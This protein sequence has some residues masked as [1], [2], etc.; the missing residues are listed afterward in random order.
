LIILHLIARLLFLLLAG[1]GLPGIAAARTGIGSHSIIYSHDNGGSRLGRIVPGAH[2]FQLPTSTFSLDSRHFAIAETDNPRT[3]TSYDEAGRVRS[4]VDAAR[5]TT[6][7][8]YDDGAGAGRRKEVIQHRAAPNANLVTSYR[9]DNAGRVRYVTDPRGNTVETQYDAQ[10]RQT[11]VIY[12]ATDELPAS[13]TETR[14]DVAGRR[15][16]AIDQEGKI[17]R[18]R[19]DG[20]GRLVEVRQYLDQTLAASDF[21]FNLPASTANVVSTTFAYDELGHQ[22]TQQDSLGRVTSYETDASGRRLKR[23]LPKTAAEATAPS[24]ILDYDT[25]GN[26]WHRTDLAGKTTTFEYD[27][28]GR[29]KRKLADSTHPSLAYSHAIARVEY[30]YDVSGARTAARTYGSTGTLLYSEATPRTVSGAVDHKETASGTLGYQYYINGQLKDVVSSNTDGVNVG[31]RYDELNRLQYVDDASGSSLQAPNP[32]VSVYTYNASGSLE[33]V[34]YA[35]GI[36]HAYNYDTLNRLRTLS[37]SNLQ[38]QILHSYT[39]RLR[40]SGH[41]RQVLEG[42]KTTTYDYDELYRLTGETVTGGLAGTNGAVSYTLDKV[43]NRSSRLSFVPSVS[44]VVNQ[45]H[46]A[47][48]RLTDIDG[49]SV[50]YDLNGNTTSGSLHDLL[51]SATGTFTDV[52]DFENRLI[53]RRKSDG[54]QINIS[55]DPDGNRVQKTIL[56]G[57][58]QLVSATY[59]LVDTNNLTGYSQVFEERSTTYGGPT[60]VSAVNTYTYGSDLISCTNFN[61]AAST[62]TTRFYAYDGHGSVRELTNEAGLVTETY[63]Y[64]AFGVLVASTSTSTSTL[65]SNLNSY[66]YSGEQWDFD[67]SLYFNRARY[68]NPNSG[69][70]WSMD[71][72]EGS[73]SDPASLHKYLYANANPVSGSDP[74]GHM[75]LSEIGVSSFI[76][77]FIDNAMAVYRIWGVYN[78]IQ[79]ILGAIDYVRGIVNLL[80]DPSAILEHLK[81]YDNLVKTSAEFGSIISRE[82][83]E[84]GFYTLMGNAP[85]IT[86]EL[87]R[88]PDLLRQAG[89]IKRAFI[90]MPTP[91][92][93][94][95]IPEFSAPTRM[96]IMGVPLFVRFLAAARA[97]GDLLAW[98]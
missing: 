28:L 17:T 43:G 48:D 54:T 7:Y 94:V 12:P 35:N 30:D 50:G 19:Y 2:R 8:T 73:S 49:R 63:T 6:E 21:N 79:T 68:L 47:R 59:Y 23:H 57:A 13:T 85:R 3:E 78:K 26:L 98:R 24:E 87:L 20:L 32:R 56:D 74:S 39:Y 40:A 71:S 80:Q 92:P 44:S 90:E 16:A 84:D 81:V 4:Q 22:T 95:K 86:A 38:S 77:G 55:Y 96:R 65:T 76:S 75:T 33:T 41:R 29:L 64:D 31:Y 53:L 69:R 27:S 82:G 91:F 83:I 97:V 52:Y 45:I 66:L 58:A 37:V 89:N 34:S 42:G 67:L 10:G 15:I 11:K 9:Y 72:Y 1:S 5:A 60:S 14:Y 25:W 46:D 88:R 62:S 51:P 61:S 18:Y 93:G 70:F 36:R